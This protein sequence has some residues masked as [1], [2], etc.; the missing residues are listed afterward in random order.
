MH[1]NFPQLSQ[2]A[3]EAR[4]EIDTLLIQE[5]HPLGSS[6]LPPWD[7]PSGP[8]LVCLLLSLPKRRQCC[9]VDSR[10]CKELRSE[11]NCQLVPGRLITLG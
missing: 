9:P 3:G 11:L 4:Q 1:M 7:P 5:T 8:F 2:G 10:M 6:P